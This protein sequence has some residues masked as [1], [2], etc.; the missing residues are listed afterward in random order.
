MYIYKCDIIK[1]VDGD[2]LDIKIDL[3]FHVKIFERVRLSQVN[4]PEQYGPNAEPQGVVSTDFVKHWVTEREDS[5]IFVYHSKRYHR[6]DKY[7]RSLGEIVW[8]PYIN[9][10]REM[11]ITSE[12]ESLSEAIIDSGMGKPIGI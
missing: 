12:K 7:G 8:Y 3:G 1:I 10:L 4:T 2:T 5:G 9:T 6:T 11:T